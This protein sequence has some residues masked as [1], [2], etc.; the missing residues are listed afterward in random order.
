[1]KIRKPNKRKRIVELEALC[2]EYKE[3]FEDENEDHAKDKLKLAPS[4]CGKHG[5]YAVHWVNRR[6]RTE[7]TGVPHEDR[8]H[9]SG[10]FCVL[11][12]EL[13]KARSEERAQVEHRLAICWQK[14]AGST[15]PKKIIAAIREGKK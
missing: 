7:D 9:D 5:H 11:C 15:L 8:T 14:E 3:C 1:M 2:A 12:A 4:P 6:K 13:A 10:G